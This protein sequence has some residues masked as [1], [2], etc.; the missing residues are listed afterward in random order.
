MCALCLSDDV[1]DRNGRSHQAQVSRAGSNLLQFMND[2]ANLED[3]W[4]LPIFA[5]P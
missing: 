4:V 1:Q 5:S 3:V 2:C